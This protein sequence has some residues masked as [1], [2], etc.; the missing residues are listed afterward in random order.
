MHRKDK[1]TAIEL[2]SFL[3]ER[4]SRVYLHTGSSLGYL[5]VDKPYLVLQ[6]QI[7]PTV[8][9]ITF[10]ITCEKDFIWI[11]RIND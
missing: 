5:Q 1:M 7:D 4:N 11:E 6:L 9:D 3:I 10:D 2:R 8:Q